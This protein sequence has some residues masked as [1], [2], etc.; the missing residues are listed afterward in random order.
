MTLNKET[1]RIRNRILTMVR[2]QTPY[3]QQGQCLDGLRPL[4]HEVR[5]MVRRLCNEIN[6]APIESIVTWHKDVRPNYDIKKLIRYIRHRRKNRHK[7]EYFN[8]EAVLASMWQRPNEVWFPCSTLCED[9]G[10]WTV[11][12]YVYSPIHTWMNLGGRGGMMLFCPRCKKQIEYKL[13]A[14]N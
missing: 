8:W 3:Y 5:E 14:M 1:I 13:L 12:A 10:K 4:M 7:G 6:T 9:C 2:R 11:A